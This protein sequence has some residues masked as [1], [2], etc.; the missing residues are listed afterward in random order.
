[1]SI[2]AHTA[3][4]KSLA[5]EAGFDLVGVASSNILPEAKAHFLKW[6]D[7]G[8][9]A[10]MAWLEKDPERRT[11]PSKVLATAKSILMLGINYYSSELPEAERL[12]I[13]R[14]ARGRDYHRYTEF[15]LRTLT[16]SLQETFPKETFK[17]YVD[18]GPFMERAY[19]QQAGIGFL[20]KNGMVISEKFGSFILLSEI[21]TSME[22]EPDTPLEQLCGEC[23]RCMDL[24]PTSAIVEEQTI[25]A[26]KCISYHTIES[27]K[28]IPKEY[29]GNDG[30][31]FGCDS[32]QEVCPFNSAAKET[33]HKDLK[34]RYTALDP[35][36]PAFA[37]DEAFRE[38]FQGTPLLRAGREKLL[39]TINDSKHA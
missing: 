37:T 38:K 3:Q 1:M 9:H 17:F 11:T 14:Y 31:A 10:D 25:D 7:Q 35:K 28:S 16:R 2:H 22:L 39:Q 24:C 32:C 12:R 20:G 27:K 19:A 29:Q 15:L 21:I 6:L 33:R 13:A 8:M 34:P 26:R 23:T 5:K 18:Y 30:W 4:V 36:D